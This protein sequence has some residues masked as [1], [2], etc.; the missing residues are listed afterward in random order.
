MQYAIQF[1]TLSTMDYRAVCWRMFNAPAASEWSN[2]LILVE[3]LFSL[4][5]SNG[6]LERVFSQMNV[7]KTKKRSLLTNES[8]DD[9]LLLTI[10]G[11]LLKDF[12]PDQ[13]IDLWW[14][15]KV[16]RPH[17]TPRKTYKKRKRVVQ[18]P[19]T[20]ESDSN[21]S[22]SESEETQQDLLTE[23]DNW[24]SWLCNFLCTSNYIIIIIESIT[25]NIDDIKNWY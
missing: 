16:R 4:P 20:T 18:V 5:A 1:V 8:L 9:L 17:Q 10:D 12:C 11:V 24:M 3:L 13:S 14:Q 19:T 23:W 21:S 6:K 7:I 25:I 15:D 2:V 22:Q